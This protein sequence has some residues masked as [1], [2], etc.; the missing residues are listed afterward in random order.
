MTAQLTCPYKHPSKHDIAMTARINKGADEKRVE[1]VY[2]T[3]I[4]EEARPG[5]GMPLGGTTRRNSSVREIR[6][7]EW[8]QV[9]GHMLRY[10]S[11][12]MWIV[13]PCGWCIGAILF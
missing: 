2:T 9:L 11:L 12:Q 5:L 6:L 7:E 3:V 10:Q 4:G 8:C 1:S 13:S